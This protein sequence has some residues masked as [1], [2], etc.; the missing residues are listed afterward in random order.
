MT[1]NKE[2]SFRPPPDHAPQ[3]VTVP[4]SERATAEQI[5]AAQ[6]NERELPDF[7]PPKY[8]REQMRAIIGKDPGQV[9]LGEKPAPQTMADRI[10]A[11]AASVARQTSKVV[12]S[13]FKVPDV[14][15][16]PP[17]RGSVITDLPDP[18]VR[19]P[20]GDHVAGQGNHY[21]H[22]PGDPEV[23]RETGSSESG[24]RISPVAPVQLGQG[25]SDVPHYDGETGEL[26][27][28]HPAV[29][30]GFAADLVPALQPAQ[31]HQPAASNTDSPSRGVP[32]GTEKGKEITGGFGVPGDGAD[33]QYFPLDGTELRKVVLVCMDEMAKRIEDDLRFSIACTYPRAHV[34]V[35]IEVDAYGME[36][37]MEIPKVLPPHTG[38]PLEVARR[39][40]DQIVFVVVAERQEMTPN[41]ESVI[42][43]NKMRSEAQLEIPR[44]RLVDT[45][46]GRQFVDVLK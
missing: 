29:A 39:Y 20:V 30:A 14:P 7:N 41:G 38:T 37:T 12:T 42:P 44:K 9:N 40:G 32:R 4:G 36:K 28:N 24:E 27:N 43:P 3:Q 26:T 34:R 11:A 5:A 23:T 13:S 33:A 8:T 6:A 2:G 31:P 25:T 16:K 35:V 46:S 15:R 21:F 19:P 18:G 1:A 10:K 17:A 45:P 22:V